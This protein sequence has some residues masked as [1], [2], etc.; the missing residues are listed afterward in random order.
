MLIR[1]YLITILPVSLFLVGCDSLQKE[2][3]EIT[4]PLIGKW[5]E[6]A[7][8]DNS[9]ETVVTFR[10]DGTF[11]VATT[12]QH[13]TNRSFQEDLRLAT[14]NF[15]GT[16][17]VGDSI[18]VLSYDKK[19]F[20]TNIAAVF[21]AYGASSVD[22]DTTKSTGNIDAVFRYKLSGDVLEVTEESTPNL[23][24]SPTTTRYVRTQ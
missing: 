18:L 22:K 14:K 7:T 4:S 8:T 21:R 9:S 23:P 6:V 3:R 2:V 1:N 17:S 13:S 19:S 10:R 12:T 20:V 5:R 15:D 24:A 11:R 16:Y